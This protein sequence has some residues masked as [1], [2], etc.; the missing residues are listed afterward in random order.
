MR[1]IIKFIK[2][3]Q[4]S[5]VTLLLLF[6][7]AIVIRS[8]PHPPLSEP[9]SFSTTYYDNNGKLLRV[10]LSSDDKYRLWVPLESISPKVIDSLMLHE[11][12]WFYYHPGFNPM[13]L[14]RAFWE[15]YIGGDNRQGASTITMQL[16]RMHWK[17][18]TKTISGKLLQITKAIQLELMYSKHDI[19]EAY[20]NYAPFGR[21]IEGIGA[22]SLIYFDKPVADVNLPEA[23][24]LTVLPQSPT[25]RIDKQTGVAGKALTNARN[26]LFERWKV[27]YEV[28]DNIA[29]LFTLPLAMRQPEQLP[30][31]A[32]HFINQ[33]IQ[34]SNFQTDNNQS[35]T[36]VTTLDSN[37]QRIIEQQVNLFIERNRSKGIYNASVLLIDNQ[38]MEIKA[39]IGSSNYFNNTIQGQVNGTQAKRSPGSTLKPFIYALGFDQSILHPMTILKDVKTD[40]GFYTPENFDL[41]FKGPISATNALIKSRNIPAVYVASKLKT[42][43]FYQFLKNANI[44]NMASEEHYGLAL[45]LGGGEVTPQELAS[46][47]AMLANQGKWQPLKFVKN[48]GASDDKAL[49]LLSPEAS[50]MVKDMLHKNTR[51]Q[52]I[53]SKK[54]RIT[55]PVY[56]KTGTSWG[57]RDAWTAGGFKDYTLIVWLGNFD[58]SSNNA[59]VGVDAATP[60]FF[61][62]VDTIDAHF[63]NSKVAYQSIPKNLKKVDICLT[64]GNLLT[65]WC[66]VKGKTW[67]IPGVSPI[68]VDTI[69]RPVM[70]ENQSGKVA[71]PPYNPLTS[72]I[73]VFEYWP[74]DLAAVFAKAGIPKKSPP[75]TTHCATSQTYLGDPPRIT[76]PLKKVVYQ[77]RVNNQKNEKISLNANA[78]GAVKQLYWFIDNQFMGHSAANQPIDW[79]PTRGGLFKVLVVDDLGRSDSRMVKVELL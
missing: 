28:D 4:N 49:Q 59:F 37:L 67:F 68:N 78:D 25:Y 60:L 79:I 50:F 63:P 7:V 22:A 54:Q 74:S 46:L 76:S 15:T 42:P 47:Y 44:R 72:H 51:K 40:F 21:N 43:S 64:S 71:C 20:F 75:N 9:L 31:S 39:L 58:G 41:N 6:I 35:S 10:T 77:F 5:L 56:W 33:I 65:K 14:V 34:Q 61:N 26:R 36:V 70:I 53:L 13:S 57:F 11:D 29:A 52:D 18:N 55:S 69:Y 73:E 16:A 23:L 2:R 12:Q 45:V 30:F 27:A 48:T 3:F 1:I 17:L 8:Y 32:P 19:L 62:I 66:K 24:T 38:T